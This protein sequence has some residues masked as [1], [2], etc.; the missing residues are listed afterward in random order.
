MKER[1]KKFYLNDRYLIGDNGTVISSYSC[2]KISSGGILKGLVK[3]DG[4]KMYY[5]KYLD[6]EEMKEKWFYCH[7]LVATHWN[8]NPF[9]KPEV[10]YDDG[11]KLNNNWTNLT[12]MTHAENIKH[13]FESLGRSVPTGENHWRYGKE[14]S[15]ETKKNMSEKKIGINHPRFQGYYVCHGIE[16]PSTYSA[17]DALK[18]YPKYIHNQCKKK[19]SENFHFK[20]KDGSTNLQQR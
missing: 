6:G 5:L 14:H 16:Y 10:N 7:I 8:P 13:T 12:W 18:T 9:N 19:P 11:N 4:Y 2:K 1:F 20:F 3:S 17:A 15:D